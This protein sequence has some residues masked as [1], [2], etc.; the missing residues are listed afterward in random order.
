MRWFIGLTSAIVMAAPVA[1][2][3]PASS[4]TI[5]YSLPSSS[6]KVAVGFTLTKCVGGFEARPDVSFVP[7]VGPNPHAEHRFSLD[8]RNLS[9]FWKNKKIAIQTYPSGSIKS[10]NGALADQTGSIISSVIKLVGS[11][12]ALEGQQPIGLAGR[13]N[14]ATRAAIAR[15]EA[16]TARIKTLRA[17]YA[18]T[19][20]A[21]LAAV[22]A[23]VN[24]LAAE[25][26]RLQTGE[27]RVDLNREFVLEPN[28]TGGT[29]L[30]NRND[31]AK[32]L[33]EDAALAKSNP[34]VS[35]L[36][37]GVCIAS[38]VPG[39]AA[40][41]C[42]RTITDQA[43]V[44]AAELQTMAPVVC[45]DD[46]TCATTIVLRE[47][48]RASITAVSLSPGFAGKPV[49]ATLKRGDLVISQWGELSYL[50]LRVGFGKSV[51]FAMGFDENGHK[52][53]QTWDATAR[54]TT[55]LG[56]A[57]SI[58]DAAIGAYKAINGE[59]VAEQKAEV[60]RLNTLKAYNQARFCAAVIEAGG[61]TCP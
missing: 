42:D 53:S 56:G 23:A 51:S 57:S 37:V 35:D 31:F 58:T 41:M 19:P 6:V 49:G 36:I 5:S 43:D 34:P 2:Q 61:F 22:E 45:P 1:A 8:G 26:G 13:C 48:R 33:L 11:V 25:A 44:R 40:P 3:Q 29:L 30:W 18:T 52:V 9:S 10:L 46:A 21:Q 4:T 28:V 12:L 15:S 39:R 55:L 54:G 20:P 27:L 38:E 47:P 24:A 14:D 60:D 17:Q 7:T 50:P 32:W 59:R 16:L